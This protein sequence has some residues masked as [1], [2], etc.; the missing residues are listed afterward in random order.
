MPRRISTIENVSVAVL[1]GK[2]K[3]V[4]YKEGKDIYSV[5]LHTFE[6]LA[7]D[8]GAVYHVKR[9]VLVNT[10]KVDAYLENFCDSNFR[11]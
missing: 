7:K 2:K 3:F 10:E 6:Q 9:R 11:P 5:G 8:A 4:S 1:S